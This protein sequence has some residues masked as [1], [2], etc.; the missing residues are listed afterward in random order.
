[1]KNQASIDHQ[2]M[3]ISEVEQVP[4]DLEI[5]HHMLEMTENADAKL[6]PTNY[7]LNYRKRFLAEL[8]KKGLKDFRQRHDSVLSSFGAVDIDPYPSVSVTLPKGGGFLGRLITRTIE[9]TPGVSLNISG[10]STEALVEYGYWRTRQAFAEKEL[11]IRACQTDRIGNPVDVYEID[12]SLWS[13][14]QLR[15]CTT[16]LGFVGEVSVPD[17][18]IVCELGPGLGRTAGIMASYHPEQTLILFDIPP[19]LYVSNQ[20]L[21]KRFGDRVVA[22]DRAIEID[23]K[24]KKHLPDEYRGKIIILPTAKMPEWSDLKIDLF[25]NSASFQEMETDV[26]ENYLGLVKKMAP[27]AIFISASPGGNFLGSAGQGGGILEIMPSSLYADCLEGDY[28]LVV[29]KMTDVL[30]KGTGT[31]T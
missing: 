21:K 20:Y 6:R 1:M 17:D 13:I 18:G 26:V 27:E 16:Y 10:L 3:K 19:Q 25:W 7:W 15:D 28:N 23:M 9:K 8:H 14:A 30:F 2:E 4:D 22:Y 11:D 29:E 31:I 12:G 5:L 24:G